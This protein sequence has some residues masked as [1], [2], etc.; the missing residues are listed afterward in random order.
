MKLYLVQHAESKP[1]EED[2][3]RP[4]TD[5]GVDTVHRVAGFLRQTQAVSV[6]EV[7]HSTKLRARQTAEHLTEGLG[8]TVPVQELPNLEPLADV[9]PLADALNT[10]T[11]DIMIV[12]HLPHLNRLASRLVCGDER[13]EAFQFQQ[14]GVLCLARREDAAEGASRWVVE[15]MV[16]PGLVGRGT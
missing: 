4:L 16:V 3:A 1:K 7:R 8:L 10:E 13:S 15:W 5:A 14:G 6:D 11:R 12:G 2:P 9:G